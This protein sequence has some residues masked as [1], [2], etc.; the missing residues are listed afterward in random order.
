MKTIY[1]KKIDVWCKYPFQQEIDYRY[2]EFY[3]SKKC[4]HKHKY[5]FTCDS[6]IVGNERVKFVAKQLNLSPK[7]IK[8]VKIN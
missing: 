8:L 1:W 2:I 7:N 4:S 3:S 6:Q 5:E